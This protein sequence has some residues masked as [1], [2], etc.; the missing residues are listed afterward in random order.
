[1]RSVTVDGSDE[2]GVRSRRI[3]RAVHA[4][5]VSMSARLWLGVFCIAVVCVVA[6]GGAVAAETAQGA[7]TCATLEPGPKRTVTR[8]ID[9][10]TVALDD[11]TE[12]RLIGALAPRALDAG[13]DPGRWPLEIAAQAELQALVLGKSIELAFG[14]ERTDRYGRLQA[15]AFIDEGGERR[16]VQGHLIEQGLAR[17]YTLAGNRACADE[18]LARERA[19]REARRGLWAEAAYQVRPADRPAQLSRHRSTFQVVEGR[20]ARVAQVRGIIYLNF[21]ADWRRAFSASLRRGDRALLGASAGDPKALE[22][23]PVRVRGWIELHKAPTVNLSV[24]GLIEL[25][26]E[27]AD[28]ASTAPPPDRRSQAPRSPAPRAPETQTPGLI[29][30]GR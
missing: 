20:I 30:A 5:A 2:T 12:L 29:E 3:T 28:A 9:G 13:A 6:A 10:E 24:G 4:H 7:P 1:M 16:W 18:L 14:G 8:V 25:L 15:H 26:D 17:A 19:A 22:G 21:A 27:P 11:G 23:K